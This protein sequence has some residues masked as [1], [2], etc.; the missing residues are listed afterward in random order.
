[1][2]LENLK[3]SIIPEIDHPEIAHILVFPTRELAA[4]AAANE[5]ISV[6]RTSPTAAIT[7]AT[8]QTM[9]PVYDYL[10]EAVTNGLVDFNKTTV[11]HLDERYPCP[12]EDPTSFAGFIL[13][14]VVKP[15][16]IPRSQAFLMN[17]LAPDPIAEARRYNEFL[18][19]QPIRLAVLGLGPVD[20]VNGRRVGGHIAFNESGTPFE[21]EVHYVAQLG[22]A[23]LNRDRVERGEEVPVGAI[24]QGPANIFQA[25]QILLVAYG[26]D[27]GK[28]LGY[29]LYDNIGVHCATSGLRLPGVGGKVIIIIDQ[30]AGSGL[31]ET[32]SLLISVE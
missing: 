11:F 1:M 3:A 7:Y 20:S 4:Q 32:K 30:E 19:S 25:E 12:P 17:G 15:L 9:E 2:S 6:V 8:G 16:G 13:N 18:K 21:S 27:K 29:A 10:A 14:R 26:T 23:T 22:G 5:I 28:S 24:T 31:L